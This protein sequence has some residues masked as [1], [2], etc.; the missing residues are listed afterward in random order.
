MDDTYDITLTVTDEDGATD[1]ITKQV[2]V[3]DNT[4]EAS[5]TFEISRLTVDFDASSSISPLASITAYSWELGSETTVST[6][7]TEI[8]HTF[9]NDGEFDV[10]LTITDE[11]GLTS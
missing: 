2:T 5:F 3:P 10:V 9:E 7:E 1:S 4:P 11:N 6:P 8:S